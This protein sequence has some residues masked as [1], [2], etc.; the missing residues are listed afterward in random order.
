M[1]TELK[2]SGLSAPRPC[3][4]RQPSRQRAS[5]G[6]LKAEETS[7]GLKIDQMQTKKTSRRTTRTLVAFQ[8]TTFDVTTLPNMTLTT[9]G[10]SVECVGRTRFQV[11]RPRPQAGYKW[12]N[13]CLTKIQDTTRADSVR[14]EVRLRL[15]KK[16]QQQEK[17]SVT[18]SHAYIPKKKEGRVLLR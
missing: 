10:M 11:L 7:E 2:Q 1:L 6:D 4:I 9:T 13:G 16:Q 5:E 8:A 17:L 15:S 18:W 14:P 12:I 3:R